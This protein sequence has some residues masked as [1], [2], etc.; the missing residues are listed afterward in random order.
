MTIRAVALGLLGVMLCSLACSGE[1]FRT[2]FDLHLNIDGKR[3]YE[4]HFERMPYVYD[5]AVF[6]FNQ[7]HFGVALNE[8]KEGGW[9]VDYQPDLSKADIVFKVTQEPDKQGGFMMM[10]VIENR[11]SRTLNMEALMTVPGQKDVF[12]TTIVPVR[13]GLTNFESWPH[14]IVKLVLRSF[15]LQ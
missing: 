11:T 6:L 2:P 12:K 8:K 14:P 10:L 3:Y 5:D 9:S 4:E 1:S 15:A 7:D 13:P